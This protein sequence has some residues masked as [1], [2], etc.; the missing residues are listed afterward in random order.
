MCVQISAYNSA[1]PVPWYMESSFLL[2]NS[3][4]TY[5]INLDFIQSKMTNKHNSTKY[6]KHWHIGNSCGCY[7]FKWYVN[8]MADTVYIIMEA[9]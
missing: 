1:L 6:I 5:N 9:V 2:S 3:F 8:M 4:I 7:Q